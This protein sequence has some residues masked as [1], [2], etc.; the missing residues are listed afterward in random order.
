[1]CVSLTLEPS[2]GIKPTWHSVRFQLLF[3]REETS[4]TYKTRSVDVHWSI[5]RTWSYETFEQKIVGFFSGQLKSTSQTMQDFD[6]IVWSVE[7]KLQP[8]RKRLLVHHSIR[9]H[10]TVI[11]PPAVFRAASPHKVRHRLSTVEMFGFVELQ[12]ENTKRG[13]RSEQT[14]SVFPAV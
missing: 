6:F 5:N 3:S 12:R 11:R 10:M 8:F 4:C 1:M 7:K 2:G 14:H 13:W 9:S